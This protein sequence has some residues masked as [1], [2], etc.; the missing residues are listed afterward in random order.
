MEATKQYQ[1]R[2]N[3]NLIFQSDGQLEAGNPVI[4]TIYN[5]LIF[6]GLKYTKEWIKEQQGDYIRDVLEI[7]TKTV[8]YSIKHTNLFDGTK[9]VIVGNIKDKEDAIKALKHRFECVRRA[10]YT[11]TEKAF[12]DTD[13]HDEQTTS[14][15]CYRSRCGHEQML[16]ITEA[17]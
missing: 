12:A 17:N 14:Y 16:E 8:K 1:V 5:T 10:G 13:V 15:F 6:T 3:G 7:K 11:I 2:L 4:Y 9:S